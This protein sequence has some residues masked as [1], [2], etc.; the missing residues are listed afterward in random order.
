VSIHYFVTMLQ[1]CLQFLIAL[2]QA[3]GLVRPSVDMLLP[4]WQIL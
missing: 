4:L 3:L 1:M 2:S